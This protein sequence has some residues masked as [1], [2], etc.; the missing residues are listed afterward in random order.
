MTAWALS[1]QQ[2]LR[3][4]ISNIPRAQWNGIFRL[5]RP[6]PSHRG[7]GYYTCK[8]DAKERCW[9]K[10]FCQM[11]RDISVRPTEMGG[12]LFNFPQEKQTN[13]HEHTNKRQHQRE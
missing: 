2:K 8:Q 1:I 4:E 11:E 7:F 6:D 13:T 9:T 5:H 12:S 10:Q 3:F